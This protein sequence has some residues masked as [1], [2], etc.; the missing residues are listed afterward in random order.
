MYT[1]LMYTYISQKKESF[2]ILSFAC[3]DTRTCFES[4][5]VGRKA[6]WASLVRIARRKLQI[7]HAAKNLGDLKIPPNNRLHALLRE[8][9]GYH[10][11][12]INDQWRI[13]FKFKDGNAYDVHITDYH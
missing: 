7:L 13:V 2:V 6:G 1:L 3:V 11:I 10:A 5:K 9:E 8:Y 12:S 4:E